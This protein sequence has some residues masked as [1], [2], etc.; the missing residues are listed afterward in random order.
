MSKSPSFNQRAA[1]VSRILGAEPLIRTINFHN[2][3]KAQADRYDRQLAHYR[4]FFSAVTEDDL[5][6]YLATGQ[7]HKQKP[8]LIIAVYEGYRNGYDVLAPLLERHGLIGWF[9]II[10]G[11][12]NSTV[13][14]QAKFAHAHYIEMLTREY[15]DGRYALTWEEVRQLE[16]KHVIASHARTHSQ[17]STLAPAVVEREVVGSQEDFEQHLGRKV[18]S[19]VSLTGP[20]YG[21]DP[22]SDKLIKLAGYDFVFSNFRIQRIASKATSA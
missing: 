11:F 19:F 3:S 1:D 16:R 5:D 22:V 21:E 9:F 14:N 6:G 8:G 17:L 12:L 15:P 7:W 13:K 10:T 4:K 20:P 2:T 18:R